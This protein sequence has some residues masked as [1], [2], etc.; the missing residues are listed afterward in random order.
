MLVLRSKLNP[1]TVYTYTD[2]KQLAKELLSTHAHWSAL[3][4]EELKG[5]NSAR[6]VNACQEEL[7]DLNDIAQQAGWT[8][9]EA[10][11]SFLVSS[12]QV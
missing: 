11:N 5:R 9:I 1:G 8:N 3:L 4:A 6:F 2:R 7:N 10:V 12:E